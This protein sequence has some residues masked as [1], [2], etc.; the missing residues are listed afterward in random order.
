M[1]YCTG[2][3]SFN[4]YLI[5]AITIIIHQHQS[6]HIIPRDRPKRIISIVI[7][8]LQRAISSNNDQRPILTQISHCDGID[9]IGNVFVEQ[10]GVVL[11]VVGK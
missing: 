2:T 8:P 7:K 1:I 4:N 6:R 5:L 3:I 10:I 11:N 9:S